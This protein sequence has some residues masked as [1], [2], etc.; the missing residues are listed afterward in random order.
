M[1]IPTMKNILIIALVFSLAAV[2]AG[3]DWAAWWAPPT[4]KVVAGPAAPVP[5]AAPA[6][7][8]QTRVCP[9]MHNAQGKLMSDQEVERV[10]GGWS[11]YQLDR[12]IVCDPNAQFTKN[13]QARIIA[14]SHSIQPPTMIMPY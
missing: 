4:P 2:V 6:A 1:E 8:E 11:S 13:A 12:Y 3:K 5:V 10:I 9:P 14:L 7:P